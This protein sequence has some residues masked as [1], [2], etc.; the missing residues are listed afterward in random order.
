MQPTLLLDWQHAPDRPGFI[1][2]ALL[3][4][5]GTAPADAARVPINLSIVLDRSGSMDGEKLQA[6]C[7]AAKFLVQRL[8]PED[9]VS[10][11]A[12]DDEVIVVAPPGLANEHVHLSAQI[13]AI[14]GGGYTNLSGGWL[15]G[16]ELVAAHRRD[17]GV[18]RVMLLTDG[19]ANEGIT[20]P[21]VLRGL[22]RTAQAEQVTT[23][24][25]GF[26]EGY[27]QELLKNMA[28]AG[29]GNLWYIE[30]PDQ[31]STVFQEEIAGLLSLAAQ[32]L[33]AVVLLAPSVQLMTVHTDWPA[34][35]QADGTS[36]QLGDLYAREPKRLLFECFVPDEAAVGD[37]NIGSIVLSGTVILA[38]GAIDQQQITMPIAALLSATGHVEPTIEHQVLLSAAARAREES[39]RQRAE[40]RIADAARTLGSAG[41]RILRESHDPELQAQARELLQ[42]G[43]KMARYE[44]NELDAR[45]SGQRAYNSRRGKGHYDGAMARPIDPTEI[46]GVPP[47]P[48]NP[49]RRRPRGKL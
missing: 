2:R 28:D 40:G 14:R 9:R 49:P 11:V 25:I 37:A 3:T 5:T 6:A 13:S 20:D 10:V 39:L 31:A 18:N 32:N 36:F 21:Q 26:G 30:R 17:G 46:G 47:S 23:T 48:A 43:E 44:F 42:L 1:V 38:D 41:E 24:T 45:Y 35:A 34:L 15:K 19:E 33:S 4:L 27:Q 29:G 8:H 22:C 7:E 12:F 16:R